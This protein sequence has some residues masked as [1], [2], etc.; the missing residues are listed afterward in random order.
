VSRLRLASNLFSVFLAARQGRSRPVFCT[1]HVTSRCN[2]RCEGCFFFARMTGL[3]EDRD[4]RWCLDVVDQLISIRLPFLYFAGGEPLL[5]E[6]L[7]D[8]AWA[9][10]RAGIFTILFT[11][12]TLLDADRAARVA[13]AFHRV[14][15]SLD[16]PERFHDQ[17]R[18][19]GAFARSVAGLK[20]LLQHEKH[21]VVG[22]HTIVDA[23]TVAGIEELVR[24]VLQRG[25]RRVEVHPEFAP[26][27]LAGPELRMEIEKRLIAVKRR[28]PTVV[29]GDEDYLRG[30]AEFL[31]TSRRPECEAE[32]LFHIGL[33]SDGKVSACCA[34]PAVIGDLNR[35]RLADVLAHL[36]RPDRPLANCPG[37]HRRDYRTVVPLFKRPW[38]TAW[39]M[40]AKALLGGK[41]P[42]G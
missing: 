39:R 35:E 29:E 30:V 26:V 31:S 1:W 6:D 38:S 3:E 4:T 41:E 33:L 2:L 40:G 15:V 22:V 13:R 5:R 37:C 11:N 42:R 14:Y 27:S 8:I 9:A 28:Y 24:F 19:P 12:G 36:R 10:R 16:G 18:G 20:C 23:E 7:P 21:V 17:R 32:S 25:V 34:F